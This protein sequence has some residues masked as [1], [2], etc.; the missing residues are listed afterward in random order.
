V[1]ICPTTSTATIPAAFDPTSHRPRINGVRVDPYVG[2]MLTSIFNLLNWMPVV[3]VP[4]GKSKSGVPLGIQ[5]AAR[6]YDEAA[7]ASVA[8]AMRKQELSLF[9]K[10]RFPDL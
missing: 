6:S 8:Y 4:I 2:L 10:Q 9:R 1:L 7:V 3:N 5:I